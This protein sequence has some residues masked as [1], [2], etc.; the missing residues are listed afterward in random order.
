MKTVCFEKKD[1]LGR[2]HCEDGPAI[3][4]KTNYE[5]GTFTG[6]FIHGQAHRT[7][8]PAKTWSLRSADSEY[9]INGEYLKH[10]KSD[11]ELMIK[12]LLE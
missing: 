8:G 5:L 7:D 4:S 11:E 3:V 1:E 6:Y 10:I 2:F 9:W 12:L